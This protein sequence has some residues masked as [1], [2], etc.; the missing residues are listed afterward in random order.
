MRKLTVAAL[1]FMLLS[2]CGTPQAEPELSQSLRTESEGSQPRWC[3]PCFNACGNALGD[4]MTH[5]HH[6]PCDGC[7]LAFDSCE[8]KCIAKGCVCLPPCY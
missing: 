4:C 3:T 8:D 1:A 2:S 5:C 6:A 7:F